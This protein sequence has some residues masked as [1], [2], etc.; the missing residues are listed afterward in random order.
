MAAVVKKYSLVPV[1]EKLEQMGAWLKD[2]KA[3]DLFILDLS[4]QDAFTDGMILVSATS[5]SFSSCIFSGT[6]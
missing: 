4:G 6:R 3:R 2:K 5:S 1:Q